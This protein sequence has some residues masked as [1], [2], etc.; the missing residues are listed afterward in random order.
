MTYFQN[1]IV[2]FPIEMSIFSRIF[3]NQNGK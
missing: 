2:G 3:D 1:I